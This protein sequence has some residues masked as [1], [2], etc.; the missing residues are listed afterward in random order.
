M[1]AGEPTTYFTNI[2]RSKIFVV[3]YLSFKIFFKI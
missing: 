3:F 1:V 2:T